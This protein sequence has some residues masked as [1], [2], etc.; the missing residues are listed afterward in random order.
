MTN[1]IQV[2]VNDADTRTAY[3]MLHI[4][5]FTATPACSVLRYGKGKVVPVLH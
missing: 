4:L 5:G 2:S 3:L 1:L